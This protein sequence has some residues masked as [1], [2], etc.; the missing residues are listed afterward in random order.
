MKRDYITGVFERDY[1]RTV[2]LLKDKNITEDA[3]L[4]LALDFCSAYTY[5]DF[6][7]FDKY[8]N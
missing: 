2:N 4:D 6:S 8:F 7:K 3:R 1:E 5:F